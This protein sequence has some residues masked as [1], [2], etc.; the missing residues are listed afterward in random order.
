MAVSK[1]G[2]TRER[3][4][5][6]RPGGGRSFQQGRPHHVRR[7]SP[8]MDRNF[9][10]RPSSHAARTERYD[11]GISAME[12]SLLAALIAMG[13]IFAVAAVGQRLGGLYNNIASEVANTGS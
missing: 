13:I 2:A 3:G 8:G 4:G 9:P 5:R 7:A 1:R 12:Y 11:S 10:P 6:A